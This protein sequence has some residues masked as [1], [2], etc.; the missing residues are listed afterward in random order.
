MESLLLVINEQRE[1]K[2]GICIDT[3]TKGKRDK[4]IVINSM[5]F[6]ESQNADGYILSFIFSF[7][8]PIKSI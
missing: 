8:N 2:G 5:I 7:Q 1:R 3:Q 6:N 4:F